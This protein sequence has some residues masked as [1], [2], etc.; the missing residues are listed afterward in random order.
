MLGHKVQLWTKPERGSI[1]ALKCGID[2]SL[3]AK[4]ASFV[5]I[6]VLAACGT[7]ETVSPQRAESLPTEQVGPVGPPSPARES[8][9][10]EPGSTAASTARDSSRRANSSR[11]NSQTKTA[12]LPQTGGGYFQNDGPGEN[13]P[14]NLDSIQDARPRKEPL[15]S[16]ANR[17]YTLFGRQYVPEREIKPFRQYG[18]ASWYGRKFHGNK[19]ANGERYDMYAMTAA[20]PTLPL[21]SYAR[22]TNAK[23]GQSVVVRVNDRGPF[24]NNRVI[25]LSYTAAHKLGYLEKGFT[26]VIVEQVAIE[27]AAETRTL[28]NNSNPSGHN[29]SI[30]VGLSSLIDPTLPNSTVAL[31]DRSAQTETP[32]IRTA[33]KGIAENGLTE[34]SSNLEMEA[35]EPFEAPAEPASV[36]PARQEAEQDSVAGNADTAGDTSR[37]IARSQPNSSDAAPKPQ[38]IYVQM[39][40]FQN[41]SNA[42]WT[43]AWVEE[44][45]E[46]LSGKM[47][48]LEHGGW[49]K[50]QAGPFPGRSQ[51]Q[52]VQ[53]Q[54]RA[55]TA[56]IPMLAV[57]A[58]EP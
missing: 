50:V 24:L 32:I 3:T 47:E 55:A 1:Q 28:A 49:F 16:S 39:A 44:H 7:L 2:G 57:R 58:Q 26:E 23:T 5:A 41:R 18:V 38:A 30:R 34:L 37:V 33:V 10:S 13:V 22:V 48:I 56:F 29:R 46:S 15:A 21:P 9:P 54:I 4:L 17:P 12:R 19:T 52:A 35:A 11:Q 36:R 8:S 6:M 20:H 14:F 51:A 45:F 53:E 40:A 43:L 25:D 27:D 42:I 31:T